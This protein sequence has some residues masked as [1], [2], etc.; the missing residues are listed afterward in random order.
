MDAVGNDS[1]CGDLIFIY[2]SPS[3]V[4][5]I[6]SSTGVLYELKIVTSLFVKIVDQSYLNSCLVERRLALFWF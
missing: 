5:L 2:L 4:L 6:T 1:V 3:Y